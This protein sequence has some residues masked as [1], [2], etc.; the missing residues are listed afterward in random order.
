MSVA[1]RPIQLRL[2]HHHHLSRR[3]STCPQDRR[4]R[5]SDVEDDG[6]KV[7]PLAARGEDRVAAKPIRFVQARTAQ[8]Q[9]DAADAHPGARITFYV[10]TF[11]VAVYTICRHDSGDTVRVSRSN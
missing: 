4:G 11:H 10:A 7:T 6:G 9:D 8:D 3:P 5:P 1:K 2:C